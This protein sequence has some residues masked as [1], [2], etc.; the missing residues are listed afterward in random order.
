MIAAH[1]AKGVRQ[2]DMREFVET[3][4]RVGGTYVVVLFFFVVSFLCAFTFFVF[5]SCNIAAGSAGRHGGVCHD[6]V[7]ARGA[8]LF[9][10][11]CLPAVRVLVC[12]M[13]FLAKSK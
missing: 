3:D 12:V 13:L 9:F 1:S 5:V 6:V 8:W 2:A 4:L 10:L 7:R 11:R